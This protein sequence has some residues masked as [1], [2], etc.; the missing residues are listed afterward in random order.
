[1]TSNRETVKRKINKIPS[2]IINA[3]ENTKKGE[4]K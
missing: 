3:N 1:M 4:N 2:L